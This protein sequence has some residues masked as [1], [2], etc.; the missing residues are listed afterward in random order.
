M[1]LNRARRGDLVEHYETVRRRKDGADVLVS[2]TVSPI[3][4]SSGRIIGASAIARD[5]SEKK[6]AEQEREKLIAELQEALANVKTLSG[7]IPIC[8]SCKK[9]RDDRG[10]WNQIENYLK[11]H[12][13][14]EFSHGI[15]P[16]CAQR[17]YPEV[18]AQISE[19]KADK[20]GK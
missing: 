7:L 15:C 13:E 12:S 19:K 16:D 6:R 11:E 10:Y 5:I 1:I 2:L 17:L 3:K 20:A 9:I 8:A 18:W 4:D 14:A